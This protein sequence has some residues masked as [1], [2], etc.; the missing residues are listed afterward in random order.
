MSNAPQVTLPDEICPL[1]AT[2]PACVERYVQG[3]VW[4]VHCHHAN[5][6]AVLLL[7]DNEAPRW[8][9]VPNVSRA[10]WDALLHI[11]A[12]AAQRIAG[13]AQSALAAAA[14]H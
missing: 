12:V 4:S 8:F 9:M 1:C 2:D 7:A 13:E 6:G 11:S 10:E 14:K 3:P 5:A